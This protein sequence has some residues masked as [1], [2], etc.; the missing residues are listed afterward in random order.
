MT[1][2]TVSSRNI[3]IKYKWHI[4]NFLKIYSIKIFT[5]TVH[6]RESSFVV[7]TFSFVPQLSS[8]T[9]FC[10][11]W[12]PEKIKITQWWF[13]STNNSYLNAARLLRAQYS[14][15]NALPL[16]ARPSEGVCPWSSIRIICSSRHWRSL[17][18]WVTDDSRFNWSPKN[19]ME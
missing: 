5:F 1:L 9:L 16:M 19:K 4:F 2:Q 11:S 18:N 14:L 8:T 13:P 7:Y 6:I 3:R 17:C 15:M 10:I 12:Y